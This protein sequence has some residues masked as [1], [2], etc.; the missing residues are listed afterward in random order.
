MITE[1]YIRNL[2]WQEFEHFVAKILRWNGYAVKVTPPTNDEGK[3]IIAKKNNISYYIECKHW[4]EDSQVGRE[5][6]EKLIGAAARDGIRNVIFVTTS[7]YHANAWSYAH[8][9]NLQ[10]LF[11]IQLLNT[12]DLIRLYKNHANT[13]IPSKEKNHSNN[14]NKSKAYANSNKPIPTHTEQEGEKSENTGITL[15]KEIPLSENIILKEITEKKPHWKLT[16]PIIQLVNNSKVQDKINTDLMQPINE[17]REAFRKGLF[18]EYGGN[19]TLHY[20]D[21]KIL[22]ITVCLWRY[23]RGACGNHSGSWNTVYNLQTGEHIPL[24]NYITV[25]LKDLQDY[26]PTHTYSSNGTHITD[27][28]NT[29]ITYFPKNYFID[30]DGKSVCIVFPPYKLACGAAGNTH[31]KFSPGNIAYLNKKNSSKKITYE[32]RGIGNIY[33]NDTEEKIIKILGNPAKIF[34]Y[35]YG[36]SNNPSQVHISV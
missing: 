33:P 32:D 1:Q 30:K 17:L 3:D 12:K 20:V 22:S 29:T 13:I 14:P 27:T 23:Q 18:Y 5:Y 11:N 7:A 8:D 16:Y 15:V 31:I 26:Y 4:K 28:F 10:G 25:T 36:N 35:D 19:Y 34:Y 2:K 6:L 24:S 9:I 21:N